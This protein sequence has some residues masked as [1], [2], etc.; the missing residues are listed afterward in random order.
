MPRSPASDADQQLIAGAAR[1]GATVTAYQLERWRT[2][3]LLARNP[4]GYPGQGHGS[5]SGP[6]PGAAGLVAWLAANARPGRRPADLALLAFA[7]GLPVPEDTV[8]SAFAAAVTRIRLPVEAALAGA[9]PEDIAEAAAADGLRF[10][11]VPARIRRIDHA[12]AQHGLDWSWLEL[13]RL[14]PRPV[15]LTAR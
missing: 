7:E 15:R 9:A 5:T 10:T 8:R 13:A 12:L 4:R 3:G 1:H 6:P 14:D 11:M 2:S